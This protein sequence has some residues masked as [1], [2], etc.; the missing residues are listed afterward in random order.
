MVVASGFLL[1]SIIYLLV[2]LDYS[3]NTYLALTLFVSKE[4]GNLYRHIIRYMSWPHIERFK[5]IKPWLIVVMY[6]IRLFTSEK[7][8]KELVVFT[9]LQFYHSDCLATTVLVL[10]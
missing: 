2:H 4:P 6:L 7:P 8:G 1:L 3:E 5:N 10:T 9:K